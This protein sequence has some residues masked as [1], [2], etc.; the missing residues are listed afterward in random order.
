MA[1]ADLMREM[2]LRQF[3]AHLATEA[4]AT[5]A[6]QRIGL[7]AA[8]HIVRTEAKAEIGTYQG[9]AGPFPAWSPLAPATVADRIRKGFTPDD[10]LLRSG[11]MRSSIGF[12]N[13]ARELFV[14]SDSPIMMWQEM[15]TKR[16]PARSPLGGAMVRKTRA[17]MFAV[18]AAVFGR[19][20]SSR[21]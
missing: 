18:A 9:A 19:F 11:A 5:E 12:R 14:G 17:A 4:I 1:E 15:G 2:N 6:R 16:I 8:G 7:A 13:D 21:R 10:P 3:A 20:G